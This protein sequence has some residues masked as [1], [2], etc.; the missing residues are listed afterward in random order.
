MNIV[1]FTQE[2]P[3]YVK[4]FFDEFLKYFKSL[5]EIKAIIISRPMG[6]NSIIELAR[7]MYNFYGLYDFIR[8]ATRYAYIKLMNKKYVMKKENGEIPKTYTLKQLANAYGIDIIERS[9]INSKHFQKLIRKYDADLFISVA[10]PVIFKEGLINIPKH[11]CINIHNAPLPKYRGML[12]NFWQLYYG[13][14]KTCITIHRINTGIDTGDI[15]AQYYIPIEPD[16]TL[17]DVIIKSKREGA[18]LM[19]KTI[20]DFRKGVV[21]YKKMNGEGSYF[22]FPT[23]N[24]VIEFKKRGRHLL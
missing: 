14:N 15:I 22:T 24:D 12:P 5:D 1:Y 4:V 23:R 10:S 18:R 11:G 17:N 8:M 19:I 20:E 21:S 2:D 9:D 7:Q 6:K 3:F 16:E 13:E